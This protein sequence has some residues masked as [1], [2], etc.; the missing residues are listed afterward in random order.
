M[1]WNV[2]RQEMSYFGI[3]HVSA[4][5]DIKEN[6]LAQWTIPVPVTTCTKMPIGRDNGHE[7]GCIGTMKISLQRVKKHKGVY[8]EYEREARQKYFLI[9][10]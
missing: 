6:R 8:D 4:S 7:I 3:G 10:C 1:I 5:L 2:R 9:D